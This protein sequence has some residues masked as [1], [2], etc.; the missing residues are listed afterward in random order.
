MKETF[1]EVVQVRDE[2]LEHPIFTQMSNGE[3]VKVMMKHHVFAVWDFMSLLKRLQVEVTAV[4]VPWIPSKNANF[5]RFINEIVLAEE[6]DED[7]QGGYI[8]H[9]ELYLKAMDEVGAD[10]RAIKDYVSKLQEGADPLEAIETIDISESVKQFVTESLQLA[11]NGKTHEVAASFF[12]GREDLIPDMFER[13]VSDVVEKDMSAHWLNYYLR[14]HIELDGD[15]HGPLAEKL[16]IS[17]CDT[18]EKEREAQQAAVRSLKARIELWSGV[19]QEIDEKS[20]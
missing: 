4:E 1:A 9:Y 18:E 20:L 14:R 6:T 15:E 5:G 17:L 10:T 7:G 8:S 13:L 16:L 2:L 3:R 12:F 11:L 19:L